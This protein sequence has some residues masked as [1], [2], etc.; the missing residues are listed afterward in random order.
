VGLG[1]RGHHRPDELSGGQQQRV[2][3]ARALVN[4]PSLLLADE[5]TGAL[6][7]KTGADVMGIFKRLHAQGMTLIVVTHDMNVAKRAERVIVLS[8]GLIVKD[9]TLVTRDSQAKAA[10]MALPLRAAEPAAA[11][12]NGKVRR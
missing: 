3:I 12:Q 5:P 1:E 2:A 8:D 7:S 6:D 10:K 9:E 11:L 4:E